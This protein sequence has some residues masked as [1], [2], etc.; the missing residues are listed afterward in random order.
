MKW[1]D[2]M[3]EIGTRELASK[4]SRRGFLGRLAGVLAGSAATIPLLPVVRGQ[5]SSNAPPGEEGDPAP[6]TDIHLEFVEFLSFYLYSPK[7]SPIL[8]EVLPVS[9]HEPPEEEGEDSNDPSN[10]SGKE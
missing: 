8:R 3:T 1:L 5:E 9:G 7:R 4:T 2:G 6:Y 10:R